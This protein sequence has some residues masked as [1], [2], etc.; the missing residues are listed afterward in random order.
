MD[1]LQLDKDAAASRPRRRPEETQSEDSSHR[2]VGP[3]ALWLG[4]T[5]EAG[6][7]PTKRQVVTQ[8]ISVPERVG[9]DEVRREPTL[10]TAEAPGVTRPADQQPADRAARLDPIGTT[11]R[12]APELRSVTPGSA[13]PVIVPAS[14]VMA[15][16]AS[17]APVESAPEMPKADERQESIDPKSDSSSEEGSTPAAPRQK[18]FANLPK[19]LANLIARERAKGAAKKEK[20]KQQD[21]DEKNKK[22]SVKKRNHALPIAFAV[23]CLVALGFV[24]NGKLSDMEKKAGVANEGKPAGPALADATALLTGSDAPVAASSQPNKEGSQAMA[25]GATVA[26]GADSTAAQYTPPASPSKSGDPYLDKLRE[27][28]G[29]LNANGGAGKAPSKLPAEIANER[30]PGS[31]P[32]RGVGHQRAAQPTFSA[33]PPTLI[34]DEIEAGARAGDVRRDPLERVAVVGSMT[35]ERSALT[36]YLVAQVRYNPQGS[37]AFLYPKN[38]DPLLSGRWYQVGDQ[39]D[40]GWTVVAISRFSVNVVSPRG[41]VFEINS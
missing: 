11:G 32:S 19:M 6:F 34:P 5:E 26:A 4:D 25:T 18:R 41:R 8:R 22:S 30:V 39:T 20:K 17:A 33:E 10:N 40:D 3:D 23:L 9:R 24:L 27:L 2:D 12:S 14:A 21:D 15:T 37:S 36:P 38:S 35:V 1:I 7:A 31:S 29:E 16:T 28:K 13:Q